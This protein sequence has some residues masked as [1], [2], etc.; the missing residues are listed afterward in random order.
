MREPYTGEL[1][2]A[3]LGGVLATGVVGFPEIRAV[4]IETGQAFVARAIGMDEST[5]DVAYLS[6]RAIWVAEGTVHILRLR[7]RETRADL[8]AD[9]AGAQTLI[10]DAV[11]GHRIAVSTQGMALTIVSASRYIS[12]SRERRVSDTHHAGAGMGTQH[13]RQVTNREPGAIKPLI[14]QLA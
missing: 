11:E 13:Q 2:V 5:A 10:I 6:Q 14:Y 8:T 9:P 1:A 7:V 3:P 12:K 4:G